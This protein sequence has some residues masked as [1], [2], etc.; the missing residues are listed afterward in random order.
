MAM[1]PAICTKCGGRIL[2]DDTN[3]AGI[4]E[5]CG[6]AF[7]TEKV[8]NNYQNSI[9]IDNATINVNSIDINNLLL[10][11]KSFESEG[12]EEKAVEYYNKV[13]DIDI[14]NAE[15]NEGLKRLTKLY[16]GMVPVSYAKCQEIEKLI[17][18]G[19]KIHAIKCAREVT[20]MQYGLA[21][22]KYFIENH[23]SGDWKQFDLNSA[24]SASSSTSKSGGCYIATAIY[25]SYDCPQVWTLRRFR[26][27]VLAV[28]WYGRAFIHIYY[29]LSPTL[30]KLFGHTVWFKNCFK[31]RL[32][33]MVKQCNK[34]GIKDTPYKDMNW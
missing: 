10:R 20:G 11:A 30:V 4:C 27:Y 21:E 33:A 19:D 1:V 18:N 16:I 22:M 23:V 14:N 24:Y 7:V 12:D 9:N 25:G 26:D 13:L 34:K 28:T 29:A 32:D 15:A 5:C 31:P 2:V 6:T 3:D 8:I 17:A